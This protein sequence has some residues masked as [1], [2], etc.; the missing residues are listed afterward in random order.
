MALPRSLLGELMTLPLTPYKASREVTLLPILRPIDGF[1]IS[2]SV[3]RF[4]P[5]LT[6]NSG[7]ATE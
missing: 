2:V 5:L 3:P 7:D 6:L 4:M 1:G